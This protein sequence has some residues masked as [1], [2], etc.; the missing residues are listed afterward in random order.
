MTKGAGF[1]AKGLVFLRIIA[2]TSTA[3]IPTKYIS[4]T[5]NE[6]F[7][8]PADSPAMTPPNQDNN[9]KFCSAGNK[10]SR[11]NRQTSVIILLDGFGSHDFRHAAS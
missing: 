6:L 5:I 2:D 7:V 10:G 9:G 11:H 4:G 1:P 3:A 8:Y